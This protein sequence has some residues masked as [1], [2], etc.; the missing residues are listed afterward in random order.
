LTKILFFDENF[1]FWRK[2]YFLTKILI[3]DQNLNALP[4]FECLVKNWFFNQNLNVWSKID[5]LTKIWIVDQN[6]NVWP[7]FWIFDQTSSFDQNLDF[8][9]NLNFGPIIISLCSCKV[10]KYYFSWFSHRI[11]LLK[12]TIPWNVET[13]VQIVEHVRNDLLQF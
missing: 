8:W 9:P 1:I 6:L 13:N 11:N 4:K 2:F 10:K 12:I 7:K 3:F 5:F